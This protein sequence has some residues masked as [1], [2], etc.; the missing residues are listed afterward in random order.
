MEKGRRSYASCAR[1]F[2]L[3]LA[4][5]AAVAAVVAGLL[6]RTV[7]WAGYDVGNCRGCSPEIDW[8]ATK[9]RR[10]GAADARTFDDDGVVVLR[11][12]LPAAY[13]AELA[14][15]CDRLSNTFMTSVLSRLVLVFYLRY[16]H[17]VDTRSAVMRDWAVHGPM[18]AWAAEMLG[19]ES[20][21]LYNAEIIFH[22]GKDSPTCRPA[23][24]RD[25]VSSPFSSAVRA[26]TFNVY[27]EDIAARGPHGD[28][29]IY[30]RG[31]HRDLSAPPK[32]SDLVEPAVAVGDILAHDPN[33][34]HTTS[35][36]GCWKRRSLQ[37][38]YVAAEMA[39]MP[40]RFAFGP[41]RMPHGPVPWTLAHSPGLAPHGLRD[42]DVLGGAW[43]PLV[44]PAPLPEEHAPAPGG[45]WALSALLRI[46]GESD[47]LARN[48]SGGLPAPGFFGFDGTVEEPDDW[49]F[50]QLPDAP[51][52]MLYHKRGQ[53]F[54]ALAAA[55][56]ESA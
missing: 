49:A 5:V 35:G 50:V 24:H 26:V 28:G 6:Q 4:L 20:V 44:H 53:G 52:K 51:I 9:S 39:G 41:N 36:E 3:G 15:E 48:G 18:G 11:N 12:A 19:A 40:T 27:L 31:S 55:Q 13:V 33:T 22:K 29:L 2:G 7:W 10:V 43:Y 45:P 47:A 34:Y 56:E 21:R 23:W 54:K 1:T 42:G 30:E 38:R 32:E 14:A 16:E 8:A 37:F 17:R 25:T 46:A